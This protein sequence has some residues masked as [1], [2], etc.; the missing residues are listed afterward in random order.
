MRRSERGYVLVSV[1]W[2]V[3]LLTVVTL[4]YHH[5]ARLEVQAARYSLDASQC[6]MTARGAVER[7][8]VEIER[9]A[10]LDAIAAAAA[11]IEVP[12]VTSLDQAW[13]R[14]I[15]LYAA[16]GLLKPGEGFEND[17]AR[18]EIEDLERYINRICRV[19]HGP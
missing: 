7:G 6:R 15:D 17:V 14:P 13:A 8:I 16:E 3:A 12:P 5:R 19:L 18:I 4:S 2:V 1:L 9:K 10:I 11:S